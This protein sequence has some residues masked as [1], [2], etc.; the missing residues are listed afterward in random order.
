MEDGSP[1][2]LAQ[3]VVVLTFTAIKLIRELHHI[4]ATLRERFEAGT[5]AVAEFLEK[6]KAETEPAFAQFLA[7]LRENRAKVP[8]RSPLCA[9]M[10]YALG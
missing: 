3:D 1:R 5:M 10:T 9:A 6:R 2:P 7:W 8:P 4:E